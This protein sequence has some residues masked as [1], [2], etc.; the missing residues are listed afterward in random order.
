MFVSYQFHRFVSYVYLILLQI[1]LSGV[2]CLW[3][4]LQN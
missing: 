1:Q 2:A 3:L 4:F